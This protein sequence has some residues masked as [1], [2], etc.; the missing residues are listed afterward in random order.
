MFGAALAVARET[1]PLGFFRG[2]LPAYMRDAR[3]Q[4]CR[5]GSGTWV[6]GCFENGYNMLQ[7]WDS[8]AAVA[9]L[10]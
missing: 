2:W 9:A 8:R 3:L 6:R 1:G 10:V 5:W 4:R 7:L